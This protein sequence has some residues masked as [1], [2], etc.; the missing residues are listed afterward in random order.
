MQAKCEFTNFSIL[1]IRNFQS[2]AEIDESLPE[3]IY[4]YI[5][6]FIGLYIPIYLY[7]ESTQMHTLAVLSIGRTKLYLYF[8]IGIDNHC[9]LV[10]P[11]AYRQLT[12]NIL[13][14][15]CFLAIFT[16]QKIFCKIPKFLL[17]DC[18]RV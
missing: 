14:C 16:K 17:T 2:D 6:I 11:R 4:I 18:Y 5:Y 12:Y 1:H 10:L 8:V 7:I 13:V 15:Q 9:R 3:R